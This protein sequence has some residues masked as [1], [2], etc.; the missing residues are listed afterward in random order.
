MSEPSAVICAICH[1]TF[2]AQT[3]YLW[4]TLPCQHIFHETCVTE[5]FQRKLCCPLCNQAFQRSEL[6]AALPTSADIQAYPAISKANVNYGAADIRPPV[7][8]PEAVVAIDIH[9]QEV[10][11]EAKIQEFIRQH[12]GDVHQDA[13]TETERRKF[14]KLMGYY[15]LGIMFAEIMIMAYYFK[16]VY[17]PMVLL[18][19]FR[20]VLTFV[21]SSMSLA[22]LQNIKAWSFCW[23]VLMSLQL[24]AAVS[25]RSRFRLVVCVTEGSYTFFAFMVSLR[26]KWQY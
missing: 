20:L 24:F 21:V 7:R 25:A 6:A 1:E 8:H 2:D 16:E 22:R 14:I 15:H 10:V 9:H 4:S 17:G 18:A 19:G 12:M 13:G 3:R 23:M 5:W 11:D 26:I